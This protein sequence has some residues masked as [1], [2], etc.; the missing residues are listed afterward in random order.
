MA[1]RSPTHLFPHDLNGGTVF[2]TQLLQGG[3]TL[4]PVGHPVT[5]NVACVLIILTPIQH[6]GTA[7]FG[8]NELIRPDT[9]PLPEALAFFE[10]LRDS[11]D[12]SC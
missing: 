12:I 1:D 3:G 9:Y 5:G 7:L 8:E 11:L 6:Q 10:G 4:V 2:V